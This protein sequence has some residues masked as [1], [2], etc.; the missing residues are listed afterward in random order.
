MLKALH[1][2]LTTYHYWKRQFLTDDPNQKLK[3]TIRS[4]AAKYPYYGVRRIW[5]M[6]RKTSD[7]SRIN[8]KK[9]QRLMHNMNI[10]GAGYR[11]KR[12]KYNSYPG[13]D[14][15]TTHNRFRRRFQTDRPLQKLSSDITEFKVPTTGEKLYLESI[16]D[17][18]NKEI[19][20]YALSIRNQV[21]LL[22]LNQWNS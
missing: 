18:Y 8:H 13:P 5:A 17:L 6:L 7:Y 22:P 20:T 16:L 3:D 10:Q 15:Q 9:V 19:V 14:G 2:S 11:R 12:V 4:L 21:W 1:L